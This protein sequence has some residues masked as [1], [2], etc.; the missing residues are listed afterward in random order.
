MSGKAFFVDLTKCT[1]CRGCQVACKQWNKLP[2]EQTQ[3]WGSYQNP[4]DL[5]ATT[6]KVVHMKEIADAKGNLAVWAFFPE[7][8]RH[9]IEPPCKLTADAYDN[10]AIVH[11]PQTGAVF[12]TEKTKALP[13]F[14]EIREACPYNIPRQHP[15]T[16]V[17]AKCTMCLDRVQNGLLPACVQVCPTGTMNFG[18]YDAMLAMAKKRLAE[19]QKRY[20]E[21]TLGDADSV[22]VIYLYPVDPKKIHQYAVASLDLPLLDRRALLARLTPFHRPT[23]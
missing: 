18:D 15:E 11:D 5:S 8:C 3:N 19:V 20:P 4:K 10:T 9:C 2:A 1:A 7:Q 17:M 14:N 16:K 12:F 22:R 23:V 21:A 13:D 6:Y